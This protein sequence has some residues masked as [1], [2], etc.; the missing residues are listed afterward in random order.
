MTTIA[1]NKFLG[2]TPKQAVLIGTLG[3]VL[4]GV[5]LYGQGDGQ[6][7]A[8]TT[9]EATPPASRRR[10]APT[11]TAAVH[12]KWPDVSLE[13]MLQHNPFA[14][15]NVA[16]SES[17]PSAEI[18]AAPVEPP[19]ESAAE[20]N[21]VANERR[22]KAEAF[23]AELRTQRVKLILRTGEKVSAMIGERLIHEGEVIDGV[24]IISILPNA[25]LAEVTQL[26]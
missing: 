8:Q 11:N 5:M 12:T 10:V 25:V 18:A 2:M 4:V 15:R 23:L 14:A 6:P 3:V 1:K 19:V 21:P 22:E 16:S 17:N 13:Q 24:R 20:A 7:A 9:T 26:D